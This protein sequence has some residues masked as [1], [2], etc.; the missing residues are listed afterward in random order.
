MSYLL[1]YNEL[2]VKAK[3]IF[4]FTP[5]DLPF[6]TRRGREIPHENAEKAVDFEQKRAN[7]RAKTHNN[8]SDSR[9]AVKAKVNTDLH[10]CLHHI[11]LIYCVLYK[12]VKGEGKKRKLRC[13]HALPRARKCTFRQ[14]PTVFSRNASAPGHHFPTQADDLPRFAYDDEAGQIVFGSHGHWGTCAS[15]TYPIK[16]NRS[17]RTAATTK[18]RHEERE[19]AESGQ[20]PESCRTVVER[21]DS[22]E[23]EGEEVDRQK[24]P[25]QH[26]VVRDLKKGDRWDSNPRHSEPQSD[27]LTN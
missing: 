2:Q 16:C 20:L 13:A 25:S 24:N 3:T 12:Q 4:A 8:P 21:A 18:A 11:N 15:G 9:T 17:A 26:K 1:I 27:A 19:R 10:L 7:L 22:K 14:V 5:C 23:G 6:L